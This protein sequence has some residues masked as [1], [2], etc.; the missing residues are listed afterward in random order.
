MTVRFVHD[1]RD[2]THSVGE[3]VSMIW[4]MDPLAFVKQDGHFLICRVKFT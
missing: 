1:K 4:F 3:G 2:E